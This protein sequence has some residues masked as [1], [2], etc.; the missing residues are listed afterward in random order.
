MMSKKEE[1]DANADAET[2]TEAKYEAS[3]IPKVPPVASK[4]SELK[5]QFKENKGK[6]IVR[7]ANG[8]KILNIKAE[9]Q[10]DTQHPLDPKV[11]QK[12]IRRKLSQTHSNAMPPSAKVVSIE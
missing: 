11:M 1:L 7:K 12:I 3:P 8:G 5:K 10:P 9:A 2:E 6:I 4:H